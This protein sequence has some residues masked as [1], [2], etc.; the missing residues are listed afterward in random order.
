VRCRRVL[1]VEPDYK[2]SYP[3][4]GLM[5]LA[6]YH[7]RR[8]D[9]VTF[10]R[11]CSL[12]ASSSYWDRIYL[13][14]LFTYGWKK[15]LEAVHFYSDNLFGASAGKVFVGGIAA[16]LLSDRLYNETG[17]Y[18]VKGP[19][20]SARQLGEDDDTVIDE[21]V[22]DY[23]IL[24]QT[25]HVYRYGS[26]YLGRTT[27]GCIRACR[28]CAVSRIEPEGC[29]YIDIKPVVNGIREQIG[30]QRQLLLLDNNVLASPRLA[31][32]VDDIVSLG[33]ERGAKLNGARR[34]V[35]FNQGLDARLITPAT[36]ALLSR[37]PLKPVRVAYDRIGDAAVFERAVGLVA[38]AGFRDLSNYLLYNFEDSPEDLWQRMHHCVE[39]GDRLDVRVW[40]FPMRYVPIADTVRGYIGPHWN[41]RL[42]RGVQCVSLVTRG[43]ISA[44]HDF[45]H[46]AFGA[47]PDEFL[48][49]LSM[50]DRYII[51]RS[52]H[53][54]NGAGE[55]REIYRS[56]DDSERDLLWRLTSVSGRR[57]LARACDEAPT[58]KLKRLLVH[59]LEK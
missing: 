3:P 22:P 21:L 20:L 23:A 16:T 37:L 38:E 27:R 33:F 32:I 39:L 51:Q 53:K 40:S 8:G 1:L 24:A 55:W 50:P 4:L 49:I 18:P 30:D 13:T 43:T 26:A 45:F 46:E 7:K 35:D 54:N 41:R 57:E 29:S 52:S 14:S 48:E 31:S 11:G 59:Y 56:L 28:F 17:V 5:K 9:D 6:A 25:P 36:V 47:S 19:L 12:E 10:V 58:G 34:E 15:V 44:R 42:L 2:S